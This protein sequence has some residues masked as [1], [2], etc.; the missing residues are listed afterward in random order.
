MKSA[1]GRTTKPVEAMSREELLDYANRGRAED[2]E[3][4]IEMIRRHRRRM[5][6]RCQGDA[7][8]V[9]PFPRLSRTG[10]LQ[11]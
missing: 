4:S 3:A 8:N 9:V 1:S 11:E 6:E 2:I 5:G 7:P 10:G